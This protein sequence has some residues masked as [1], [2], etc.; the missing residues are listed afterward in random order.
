MSLQHISRGTL[1]EHLRNQDYLSIFF[2]IL[3]LYNQRHLS[4]G[5]VKRMIDF[6]FRQN[7]EHKKLETINCG[8]VLF[9]RKNI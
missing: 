3:L 6:Y 4:I 8:Q 1:K 7:N 2:L 5:Q 9:N